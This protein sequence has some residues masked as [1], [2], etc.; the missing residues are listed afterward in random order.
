MCGTLAQ[1]THPPTMGSAT[2]QDPKYS[3]FS[4]RNKQTFSLIRKVC[5]F[6]ASK[7]TFKI[8]KQEMHTLQLLCTVTSNFTFLGAHGWLGGLSVRPRLRSRFRGLW[9]RAPRRGLTAQGWS[10]LQ[11]LCFP[12][13]LPLLCSCSLSVSLSFKNKIKKKNK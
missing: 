13:S 10:L 5:D 4:T 7:E 2:T 11:I 12:L 9:V 6:P 1:H 8:P 3:L